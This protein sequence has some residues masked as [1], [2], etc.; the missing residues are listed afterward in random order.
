MH[1]IDYDSL[2]TITME[3]VPKHKLKENCWTVVDGL[4]YDVTK[5][6][7][8]HPGGRK[9]MLGAGKEASVMFKRHHPGLDLPTSKL[10]KLCIG[11]IC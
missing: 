4:V 11:R 1:R 9:I 2:P 3:E 10:S 6:I 5:Y 7:P 8:L